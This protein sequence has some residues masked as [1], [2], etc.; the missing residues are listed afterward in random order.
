MDP[1]YLDLELTETVLMRHAK[2]TVS[3]LRELKSIGVRLAVDDFGTGYSSL[4]YL[5]RFP[6][7]SLK[8]DQSFLHNITI[9][10]DDA[11][12]VSAM[13]TM[14]KSLKKQVVAEGVETEE[15]MTFL[16]AHGCDEAQGNYFSTPMVA[17]QFARLL[18]TGIASFVPYPL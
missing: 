2:S 15:Q 12:M 18:E 1:C 5:K 10:T 13:I 9:N 11:T 17:E 6:V 4:G 3:V 8:I 7:D 16:R 14:A